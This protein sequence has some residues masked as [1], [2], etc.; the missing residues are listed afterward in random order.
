MRYYFCQARRLYPARQAWE[1][2]RKPLLAA[3][4]AV[5]RSVFVL[6]EARRGR[7]QQAADTPTAARAS[8]RGWRP[9]DWYIFDDGAYLCHTAKDGFSAE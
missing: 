2:C 7:A 3:D 8:G 6:P 1:Q 4:A 9:D 5:S